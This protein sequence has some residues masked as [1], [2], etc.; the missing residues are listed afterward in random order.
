PLNIRFKAVCLNENNGVFEEGYNLV[1]NEEVDPI[2]GTVPFVNSANV[3]SDGVSVEP[4]TSSLSISLTKDEYD[5][6]VSSPHLLLF[7]RLT[8]GGEL[9]QSVKVLSTNA[10][11][12]QMILH[13]SGTIN[14]NDFIK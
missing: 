2:D 12:V 7:Y 13:F 14:L 4:K 1:F 3:N 6:I 9:E 5:Q 11:N 10:M 8:T